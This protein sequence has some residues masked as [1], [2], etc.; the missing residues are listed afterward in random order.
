MKRGERSEKICRGGGGGYFFPL[1]WRENEIF[2]IRFAKLITMKTKKKIMLMKFRRR[3]RTSLHFGGRSVKVG[4]G[5]TSNS[6][7]GTIRV[8]KQDF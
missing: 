3:E 5:N 7:G 4:A 8:G 2:L 1:F 6:G